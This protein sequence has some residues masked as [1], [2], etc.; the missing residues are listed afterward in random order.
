[1]ASV[2]VLRPERLEGGH[3]TNY[4][5]KKIGSQRARVKESEVKKGQAESKS[6]CEET[7]RKSE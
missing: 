3:F 5:G 1:M 2:Q 4:R 7:V 6:L